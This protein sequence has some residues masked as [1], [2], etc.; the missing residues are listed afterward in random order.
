[1][2]GILQKGQGYCRRVRSTVEGLGFPRRWCYCR[3]DM[4]IAEGEADFGTRVKA[5]VEELGPLQRN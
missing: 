1:M 2:L 3:R 4:D 5:S